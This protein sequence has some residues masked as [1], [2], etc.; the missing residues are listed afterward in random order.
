MLV[1]FFGIIFSRLASD[2]IK[3]RTFKSGIYSSAMLG[4]VVKFIILIISIVIAIDQV[5]VDISF[6]T[7]LTYIILASLLLG[8]AMAF[9]IGAKSS[10][11]NILASYYISRTYSEGN[12]VRIGKY[13]GR[14]IKI[15]ST[16]VHLESKEGQI[17]IPA[18][19]F[20]DQK[21]I[22]ISK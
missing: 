3:S 11:S 10:V 13:E 2:L 4:K 12:Y 16:S 21:S 5:G 19:D 15:S 8:A 17:V 18:K 9:G 20:N 7:S 6:L 14:I 1:V 22:L